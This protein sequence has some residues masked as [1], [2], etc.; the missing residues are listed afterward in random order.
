MTNISENNNNN[1]DCDCLK[2]SFGSYFGEDCGIPD[3]VYHNHRNGITR[4]IYDRVKNKKNNFE[5]TAFLNERGT[6][7]AG[8]SKHQMKIK[9]FLFSFDVL[10]FP[11][12]DFLHS[13]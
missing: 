7:R 8:N 10:N 2:K 13:I 6:S 1:T 12:L 4:V 11:A 9:T 3:I 5:I